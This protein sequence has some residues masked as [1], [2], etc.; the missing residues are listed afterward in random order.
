MFP[1]PDCDRCLAYQGEYTKCWFVMGGRRFF[2]CG[3]DSRHALAMA[4]FAGR[5][6]GWVK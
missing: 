4:A 2:Y 1:A 5:V 6:K 3:H